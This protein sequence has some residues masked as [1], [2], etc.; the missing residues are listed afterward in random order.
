MKSLHKRLKLIRNTLDFSRAEFCRIPD[1]SKPA[2]V[3]Y[4]NGTR[5]PNKKKGDGASKRQRKKLKT[6]NL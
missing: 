3:R 5:E 2:Y 6:I 1:V 4:E